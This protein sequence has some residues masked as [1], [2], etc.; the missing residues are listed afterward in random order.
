MKYRPEIDGLRTIA[1]L[2]VILFHAGFSIFSGGY[3]GVDVFF[4]ISGYLITTILID[5]LNRGDFSLLRFY[6]RRARRIL[7][8]LFVM[9]LVCLP[10]AFLW[11]MPSELELFGKGLIA[12]TLFVANILF[13][14][15]VDYFA[16]DSELNP[17]LHTWSLAVEEQFYVI[18]PVFLL[19][20][21]RF[22]KSRVFWL[23]VVLALLSL[24]VAEWGWRHKPR[25]NFF[26]MP[27]RAWE[28]AAGS[29]CAFV[30]RSGRDVAAMRGAELAGVAGL[31]MIA[32]AVFAYD[33]TTPFPSVYALVPVVGTMLIILFARP[34]NMAGR[35]LSLPLMVGIGL[36]S[37][38]AYLWHQPILVFARLRSPGEPSPLLMG[39]LCALT[40]VLAWLSWRFVERPFR[41][42]PQTILKTRGQVFR[43]SGIAGLAAILIGTSMLVPGWNFGRWV[44]FEVEANDPGPCSFNRFVTDEDIAQCRAWAGFGPFYVLIGDSHAIS[45]SR[46]IRKELA[47]RGANLLTLTTNACLPL[48]GATGS[49]HYVAQDCAWARANL[50]KVARQVNPEAIIFSA[51]WAWY[52]TS[53]RYHSSWGFEEPGE[54]FSVRMIGDEALD[55]QA[56]QSGLAKALADYFAEL[57]REVPVLV[58]EQIPEVGGNA[59]RMATLWPDRLEYPYTD[60]VARNVI[61][62]AVF[63]RAVG[64]S[65]RVV[66][67]A[68]SDLL[69]PA[70]PERV[71]RQKINGQLLYFDTNHLSDPGAAFIA[72]AIVARLDALLGQR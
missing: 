58:V 14:R 48:P 42:G 15:Q 33:N 68:P 66:R 39:A 67:F 60:Y 30:L 17:L 18:F 70:A 6:D 72:P 43:Y 2:P 29:L 47:K 21:W 23:I 45:I 1:V 49:M 46:Q 41:A 64:E 50:M 20:T 54:T 25:S 11:L 62:T 19:L 37:Y 10:F 34:H 22:G 32:Y 27:T 57:S 31:V 26:L 63:D 9:M 3:V 61:P 24:G 7:P 56:A 5:E 8:A 52:L 13:S 40:L 36:I 53:K 35:F 44:T 51:R 59:V 71:C 69:C 16:P 55:Q 28:L 4:V 12:V 38:S 65:G